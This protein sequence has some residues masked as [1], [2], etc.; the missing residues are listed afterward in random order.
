MKFSSYVY[1]IYVKF[2]LL[3]IFINWFKYGFYI[4]LDFGSILNEFNEVISGEDDN[5][6]RWLIWNWYE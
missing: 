1:Y 6:I 2:Y 5:N 3:G 4:Y